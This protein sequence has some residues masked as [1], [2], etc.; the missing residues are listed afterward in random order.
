MN[1]MSGGVVFAHTTVD[2]LID[3][4]GRGFTVTVALPETV[5]EGQA[6]FAT[7]TRVYTP[8]VEVNI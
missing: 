7:E 8:G 1:V 4:V 3:A 5:P 2:P 6:V